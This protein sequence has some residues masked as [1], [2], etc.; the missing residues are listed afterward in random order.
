MG[1]PMDLQT[2]QEWDP[3]MERHLATMLAQVTW[4]VML[5]WMDNV[6]ALH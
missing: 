6:M 5:S 2:E 3:L 4:W 1:L